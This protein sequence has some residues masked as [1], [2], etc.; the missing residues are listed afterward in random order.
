MAT[1]K[2]WL[3]DRF[4]GGLSDA[5]KEGPRG[6]FLHGESLDFRTDPSALGV[7]VKTAKQSSTTVT[8][9]PKWI[10]HDGTNDKTYA[11]GDTGNWYSESA[12]T[13]TA[14]TALTTA[15]GQGMSIYDDYLYMRKN[16]AI[17]RYG[18][19]S[20]S[21]TLTQ[22]WQS[23]NI[24]TITTHAPSI[25]FQGNLYW[26]NGRYLAEWDGSI[27]T[28]NK[29]TLPVGWQIRALSKIGDQLVM[30]GW[31]GSTVTDYEKG[32]L[33]FW[34]GTE[35]SVD[36]FQDVNEGAVNAM[37]VLDNNLYYIAGSQ[38]NIYVYTGNTVRLKKLSTLLMGDD[39]IE[40][41]PGA[42]CAHK[43]D[44]FIGAA[45]NTDS[46]AFVHGVY[47]YGRLNKNYPRAMNIEH[48]I[49]TGTKT[50]TGMKIGAIHSVGP[51]EF[52]IGWKDASTY[53]I[54]VVTGTTPYSS[55][56]WQSLIFDNNNPYAS[57]EIDLVKFTFKPLAA[58]ESIDF[59]YK[60]DRASSWT[61]LGTADTDSDTEKRFP[62]QPSKLCKEIQLRAVLS[63]SGSTAPEL[64]STIVQF[65]ERRQ[66]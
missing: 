35:T 31:K 36:S 1:K 41:F 59:Y 60:L 10:E 7:N 57:K 6:S 13:W 64:L 46:N 32:F 52:Y 25:E 54:D 58:G 48:I 34:Q 9:L 66:F 23:S 17:A 49:S 14:E 18:P 20:S 47:S 4:F 11:Y 16:A 22:S 33:W 28:Y 37:F 5:E 56:E 45:A 8:D 39:Y 26:G 55:A 15:A 38:G 53:G 40:I 29:L 62:I 27:F 61:S 43:G 12:G 3:I 30:G 44:L 63:T 51:N 24:Q 50:G 21:P 42:M 19:L 2:I 65:M